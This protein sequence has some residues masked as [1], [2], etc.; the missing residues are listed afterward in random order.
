MGQGIDW[1]Y[2]RIKYVQGA[3]ECTLEVLAD[4][5]KAPAL[6]TLKKHSSNEGWPGQRQKFRDQLNK[7]VLSDAKVEQA[8]EKVTQLINRAEMLER[9]HKIYRSVAA[10]AI[11]ALN[12]SN[13]Q[14]IKPS[15]ALAMIKWAT[16]GERLL[17]GMETDKHSLVGADGGAVEVMFTRRIV[18]PDAHNRD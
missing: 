8:A 4:E 17:E 13:P 10:L 5:P 6:S 16:D 18:K 3:D 15:D 9:H 11:A 7:S 12:S 14:D 2:W 1:D